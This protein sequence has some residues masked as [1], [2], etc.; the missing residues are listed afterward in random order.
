MSTAPATTKLDSAGSEEVDSAP[1][2]QQIAQN[3][4]SDAD[5]S[6]HF[7]DLEI[8]GRPH[9][10]DL[11]AIQP[12]HSTLEV[13]PSHGRVESLGH[14][15]LQAYHPGV[16]NARQSPGLLPYHPGVNKDSEGPILDEKHGGPPAVTANAA[17]DRRIL[18]LRRRNFWIILALVIVVVIGAAIG[19]GVGGTI[20]KSSS[21][22]DRLTPPNAT[23]PD[24]GGGPN[25]NS[26]A[27]PDPS[28]GIRTDTG[29]AAVAWKVS[30]SRYQYR[31]Y[32]QG[33]DNA[34]KESAY[35]SAS[36]SWTVSILVDGA[37]VASNTSIAA[38]SPKSAAA[39]DGNT[40]C[41]I[42]RN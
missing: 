18:G 14:S 12:D 13:A 40:V 38:A 20:N 31:V 2:S 27:T 6:K 16:S 24:S 35:D 37:L 3:S 10:S 9:Y 19:G 1:T 5:R 8:D 15:N 36:G 23:S 32:Y 21:N 39:T 30:E 29:L 22:S 28:N 26:T 34:L 25:S 42:N 4:D 41:T 17:G 33:D 7:S 11:E